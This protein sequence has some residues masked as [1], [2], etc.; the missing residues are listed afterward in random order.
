MNRFVFWGWIVAAFA[1]FLYSFTQVDLS[2]TLSQVSIWQGIQKF[3]QQIGYFN[4][5]LSTVLFLGI[6][7]GMF[8]LYGIT[9]NLIRKN[10]IDRK[11]LWKIII[12]VS[13]IL[14][15]SYNAFSYDLFNYIF[16]A[17][18]VTHYGQNPYEH[19]ALDYP[20]DPMLSFMHWTHR[21]YPYGPVWL[22]LT[23]PA[24]FIGFGYFLLT[25]YLFKLLILLSYIGSA[26]FIR[27]I[28]ARLGSDPEAT[29]AVFALNPLVIIESLVSAHNDI[30]M[31][32]FGLIAISFFFERKIIHSLVALVLSV[33]IKFATIFILPALLLD[34]IFKVNRE[35]VIR[36]IVISMIAAMLIATGR[37]NFQPWYLLF[38]IPFASLL[39]NK[40]YVI[41]PIFVI[42]IFALLQYVPFLYLGNWNPPV[43]SILNQIMI[44]SIIVSG[45]LV[46]VWKIRMSS[47][48]LKIKN[49]KL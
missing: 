9:L 42:S 27:K 43:P 17:K 10:I 2:L 31:A 13:V 40:F 36:A 1:L 19:K 30:I 32:F 22:L 34:I 26:F 3:F 45:V 11:L 12:F 33:A 4:R 39:A 35:T 6:I 7:G 23:I 46:A 20:G 8:A 28:A 24:S 14:F 18:I 44:V 48:K 15:F 29:V 16:D 37:T 25:F 38:V 21:T 41:I 47:S 49:S 5:P